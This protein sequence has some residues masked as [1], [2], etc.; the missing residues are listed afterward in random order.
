[1]DRY[2][3]GIEQPGNSRTDL[4]VVD[5]AAAGGWNDIIT[6]M[7]CYQQADDVTLLEVSRTRKRPRV[8]REQGKRVET[9]PE[10]HPHQR[11]KKPPQCKA[12]QGLSLDSRGDWI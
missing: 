4:P 5:V 3:M 7:K 6:L 9:R 10:T 12:L 2:G 11:S 1:M 8:Q